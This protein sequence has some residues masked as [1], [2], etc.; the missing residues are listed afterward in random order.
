[1]N[2][3]QTPTPGHFRGIFGPDLGL[4]VLE[5]VSR[6]PALQGLLLLLVHVH[7]VRLWQATVAGY[8]WWRLAG[9]PRSKSPEITMDAVKTIPKC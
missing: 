1:M 7:R 4:D 3:F 2:L 8:G 6:R 5:T 9:D